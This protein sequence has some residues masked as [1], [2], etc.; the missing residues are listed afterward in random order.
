M[1]RA[2]TSIPSNV[3]EGHGQMAKGAFVRYLGIAR[4]SLHE[5]ETLDASWPGE[6]GYVDDARLKRRSCLRTKLVVCSGY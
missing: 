5:L 3:A 6:F 1:V 4:G 2:A